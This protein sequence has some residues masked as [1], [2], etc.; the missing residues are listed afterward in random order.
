MLVRTSHMTGVPR[1]TRERKKDNSALPS[2]A[3]SCVIP[4]A[5]TMGKTIPEANKHTMNI[6]WIVV[7]PSF[8]GSGNG[9][10]RL[11]I[12]VGEGHTEAFIER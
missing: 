11:R 12:G 3:A 7:R 5:V 2:P 8:L 10:S 1:N 4:D 6:C 9:A